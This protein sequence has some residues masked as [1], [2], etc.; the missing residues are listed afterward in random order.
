MTNE[1]VSVDW[2]AC[3]GRGV[4]AELLPERITLDEWGFPLIDPA[5]IPASLQRFAKRAVQACPTRA[6]RLTPTDA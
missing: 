3:S 2:L 5:P 4:C 1:Q 6:L